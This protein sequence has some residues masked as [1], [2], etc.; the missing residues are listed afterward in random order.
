MEAEITIAMASSAGTG[1]VSGAVTVAGLRVHVQW[2][3]RTVEQ[4]Q[5]A[6]AALQQDHQA[7]TRRIERAD[8]AAKRA[9]DKAEGNA[10]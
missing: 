4:L 3:K 1:I 6:V 10:P 7:M 8:A 9:H 2:L 5:Y